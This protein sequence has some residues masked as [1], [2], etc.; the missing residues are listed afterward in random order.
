MV[1]V[2]IARQAEIRDVGMAQTIDQD[3]LRFAIAMDDAVVMGDL[4]GLRYGLSQARR[5]RPGDRAI[6]DQ[7]FEGGP[8][9]EVH[10]VVGLSLVLADFREW[11]P[12][13]DGATRR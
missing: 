3:I 1:R 11:R 9:D 8:F 12:H 10:R 6:L 7:I 13:S 5:L 2:E 4:H